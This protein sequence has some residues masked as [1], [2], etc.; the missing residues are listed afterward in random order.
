MIS[1]SVLLTKS[2]NKKSLIEGNSISNRDLLVDNPVALVSR[3]I[4]KK[5]YQTVNNALNSAIEIN[6]MAYKI[7]GVINNNV[8]NGGGYQTYDV[9]VPRS[10]FEA[11]NNTTSANTLK[12]TFRKGTNVSK[13]TNTIVDNLNKTSSQHTAGRYEFIDTAALLKGISAVIKGITYFIVAVA[14]ISLFIAG[15][16]VMN[17]MY[18][19]LAKERKKLGFVCL[20]GHHKLK[21]FGSF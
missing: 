7:V 21:Y 1:P 16:G 8:I 12:L 13:E 11:N 9:V 14:S 6:G 2:T 4:A 20:W 10:I 3:S 18:N 19:P 5:G 15:I 17:M